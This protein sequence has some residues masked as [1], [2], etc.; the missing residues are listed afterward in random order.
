MHIQC[1]PFGGQLMLE[2]RFDVVVKGEDHDELRGREGSK[3]FFARAG[4]CASAKL[5]A[6]A[7]PKAARTDLDLPL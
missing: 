5:I 6:I 4:T 2:K 3:K 7:L 1:V